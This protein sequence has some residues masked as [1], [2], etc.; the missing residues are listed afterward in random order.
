MITLK[1]VKKA[2]ELIKDGVKKTPLVNCPT[3]DKLTKGEIYL[4]LEN[5]QTIGSFKI[6]GA[7][8]KIKS[9]SKAEKKKGV[10]AASAGN[11]AQGVAISARNEGIKATIVMSKHAP[12]SKIEATESYGAK[13]VLHGDTFDEAF[14][15]SLEIQ[16]EENLV[17][18][19]AFDD[20]KV[21][22]GQG[23]IA[24]EI[25]ED[26]EDVDTIICSVGGGGMIAGIALA[27]K[28]INKNIKVIGVQ[29]SNI[30]SMV[31]ALE[32]GSPY[33]I[34]GKKTVADG[35]AVGKPGDK[36]F[37]IIKEYVD[38]IITVTESEIAQSMLFLLEKS[39]VMAEGAGAAALA[40]I[41]A[42]KVDLKNKK[43][44]VVVSGGN[45]DITTMEKIINKAL[46][47][48]K[49]RVKLV[50]TLTDSIG[51]LN[52]VTK[53]ISNKKANILYLN[54]TKYDNNL[55]SNEQTLEIVIECLNERHLKNVL[56]ACDK[57]KIN[58][59][60]T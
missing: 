45:V 15:K 2:R 13:V 39:K 56:K 35:I 33:F 40:S 57:E 11:H 4:K 1:D 38:E 42:K 6:R 3:L 29:T 31:K 19:H 48:Q 55:N 5:L 20:E 46:L 27:A 17:F 47:L 26:L 41:L 52:L 34:T 9:L 28:S 60:L 50:M 24:L 59:R 22:A 25:L 12:I 21:I 49:R 32:K 10:I 54:Q 7:M 8:N 43:V 53:I 30:P 36:T 51:Q 16:K 14:V 44:A 18:V 37:E 23:T 58:Y